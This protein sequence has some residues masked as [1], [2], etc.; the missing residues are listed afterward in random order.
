MKRAYLIRPSRHTIGEFVVV[1]LGGL[2]SSDTI[3]GF[4]RSIDDCVRLIQMLPGRYYDQNGKR[5]P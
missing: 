2:M 3:V 5:C 1:K 4:G